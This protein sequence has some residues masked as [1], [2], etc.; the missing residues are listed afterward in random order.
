MSYA[1]APALGV[2]TGPELSRHGEDSLHARV[3]RQC[4]ALADEG[5]SNPLTCMFCVQID[6]AGDFGLRVYSASSRA[7]RIVPVDVAPVGA[8]FII[9][10]GKPSTRPP[11]YRIDNRLGSSYCLHG[12]KMCYFNQVALQKGEGCHSRQEGLSTTL[13][14]HLREI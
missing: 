5:L 2:G 4:W 1:C 7:H 10:V 6:I 13:L 3:R 8:Q 12:I 11:P 14:H 9:T